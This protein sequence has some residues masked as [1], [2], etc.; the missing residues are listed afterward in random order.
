[1]FGAQERIRAR[2]GDA[3]LLAVAGR[4]GGGIDRVSCRLQ[5]AVANQT[6]MSVL[7]AAPEIFRDNLDQ[8]VT[9]NTDAFTAHRLAMASGVRNRA[10][11]A[12]YEAALDWL[13]RARAGRLPSQRVPADEPDDETPADPEAPEAPVDDDA[14]PEAQ[15]PADPEA[16]EAPVDDDPEPEP[17][18]PADDAAADN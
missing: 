1:M 14:E 3:F 5:A 8:V 10:V 18:L 6:F 15:M 12:D 16:P 9:A 2:Y 7:G 4:S 17:E 13:N 11:E